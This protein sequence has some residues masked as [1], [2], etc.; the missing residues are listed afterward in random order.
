MDGWQRET[1]KDRVC[2]TPLLQFLWCHKLWVYV[3]TLLHIGYRWPLHT[4]QAVLRRLVLYGSDLHYHPSFYE[5]SQPCKLRRT[6]STDSTGGFS[7]THLERQSTLPLL[8]TY[9]Q[10]IE[11]NSDVRNSAGC[12]YAAYHVSPLVIILL[13][14]QLMPVESIW[15]GT[16]GD[17]WP[18]NSAGPYTHWYTLNFL[19]SS[20]FLCGLRRV[21][22]WNMILP[23]CFHLSSPFRSVG[24]KERR[25]RKE[26]IWDC[27]EQVLSEQ[28]HWRRGDKLRRICEIVGTWPLSWE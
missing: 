20:P 27:L 1:E 28:R 21:N 17:R 15:R 3:N 13:H 12:C 24:V 2:H 26:D 18:V 9:W 6:Q 4:S 7:C 16:G 25:W 19:S 8:Q 5:P 14:S 22:A 23:R 10:W 11:C